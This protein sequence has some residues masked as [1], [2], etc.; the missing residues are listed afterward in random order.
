M[1]GKKEI[2]KKRRKEKPKIG[3]SSRGRSTVKGVREKRKLRRHNMV[4]NMIMSTPGIK[5]KGRRKEI[6][7]EKIKQKRRN[8]R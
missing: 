3:G 4:E 1:M 8:C 6:Q 5:N 7:E 2:E